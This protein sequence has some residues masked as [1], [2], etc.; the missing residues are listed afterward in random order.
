M[1]CIP[2]NY[3][4]EIKSILQKHD[5]YTLPVDVHA[6][7]TQE[8]FQLVRNY[9]DVDGYIIINTEDKINLSGNHYEKIISFN[10]N[11]TN[12]RKNFTIA[13]E[14]GHYYLDYTPSP[15]TYFA[16]RDENAILSEA[17]INNFASQLLMPYELL[18][19]FIENFSYEYPYSLDEE[20]LVR[21]I[22]RAGQISV[23]AAKKRLQ[24]FYK[25]I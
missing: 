10:D 12:T 6:L 1:V 22:A 3:S 14:L 23:A 16:K 20:D 4:I 8:G 21:A 19:E 17:Y 13:H 24:L 25:G 15:K 2:K 11:L 5:L 7:A 9:D 18:E